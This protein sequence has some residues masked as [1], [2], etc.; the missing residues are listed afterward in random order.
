MKILLTGSNGMSGSSLVPILK[1]KGHNT[2]STDISLENGENVEYLDVKDFFE[3]EKT[4]K[5]FNPDLIMHLAAETD[6]DIC[7]KNVDHAFRTNAVGTQNV[8]LLCRKYGLPMLYMSSVGVFDGKKNSLYI[9]SDE[10]KPIN[11]YGVT[12]LEG[13]K[14]V[15]NL[16]SNH[17]IVRSG[18]MFG[19]G[20][21]KDK[22]FVGKIIKQ[23]KDGTQELTIVNDKIGTPT[24]TYELSRH[25]EKLI[26]TEFWGTYHCCCKGICTRVDVAK[27]ILR[28]LKLDKK[29]SIKEVTSA[30][31]SLP[32]QRPY[33]ECMDNLMLRLRGMDEMPNWKDC[34]QE[35][36]KKFS[37]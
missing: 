20:P 15:R 22:K 14:I 4:I 34:V 24:Y 28:N 1:Q 13:E 6:V 32:A 21:E 26:Q 29:I 11:T 2:L 31:Y 10:P 33:S 18:W 30:N 8:S 35:Y 19:G 25:L 3:I 16:V 9:E 27:E 17:F 23:I 7:E 37:V 36:M 12:K 5:R